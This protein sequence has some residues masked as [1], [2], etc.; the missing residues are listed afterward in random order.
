MFWV[1]IA[2]MLVGGVLGAS[3]L[4]IAKK[5]DAKELIDKIR[6][7]QGW[8]G[9]T[10]VIWGIWDLIGW[11]RILDL[12]KFAP[13]AAILILAAALIELGLGFLLG[14]GLIVQ[15]VLSK[16]EAA[17]KKGEEVYQKLS[18]YQGILGLAAI[19]MVVVLLLINFGIIKF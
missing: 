10:L 2:L 16:N 15:Y 19:A 6:P 13:I 9:A 7:Y 1:T 3:S 8:I 4:I 5:P 17:K 11:L 18:G 14:Y 12:F